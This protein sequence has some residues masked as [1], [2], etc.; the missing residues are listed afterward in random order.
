[1]C[2]SGAAAEC[3]NWSRSSVTHDR[4]QVLSEFIDAWNAGQRP[5]V[6]NYIERVAEPEREQLASELM[7]FLTLA[8]SPAYTDADIEAMRLDPIVVSA[9]EA[10]DAGAGVLAPLLT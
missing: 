8:P 4:E 7:S 1:M 5:D 3:K 9:R 6:D 10:A 2:T